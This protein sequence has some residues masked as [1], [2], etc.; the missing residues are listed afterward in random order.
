MHGEEITLLG[1]VS[2]LVI[3]PFVEVGVRLGLVGTALQKLQVGEVVTQVGP[4]ARVFGAHVLSKQT[5]F[6]HLVSGVDMI[7]M[8]SIGEVKIRIEQA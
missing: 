6:S 8:K 3:Q 5:T 1:A 4:G 2:K 7:D